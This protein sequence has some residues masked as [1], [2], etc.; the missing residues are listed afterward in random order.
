MLRTL[1]CTLVFC[2][3]LICLGCGA[4]TGDSTE[5]SGD[6]DSSVGTEKALKD[7]A[8]DH[9]IR[10]G[11]NYDYELRGET[12]DTIFEE[13]FNAMTAGTFW[14]DG[15]Y[16]SRTESDFSEMDAKVDWGHERGMELHG[17]ILV[18]F[19]DIPD[20]V[21]SAPTTDVESIMN[22]HIDAVVGRYAGKITVWDV[23]NEAVNDGVYDY[24]DGPAGTLRRDHKWFEAMG[25]DYIAKAFVR[26]HA[27]DPT[28]ILRYND[29]AMESNQ[30]KYEGV[31]NLLQ[32]LLD[33][34]V[35]VHALGWQMHVKPGS[36]D[37][38]TLLA[39]MNEIADMGLDNYITE[40]DVELPEEATADDYEQQKQTFKSVIEVF[41]EAKRH[42]T[43]VF[44]GLRDG[45]PHWLTDGHPL[46]F[47]ED[48]NKKAA[49]DGVQE[50][51]SGL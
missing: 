31:K 42:Q 2:V 35:P 5:D 26:A 25:D 16:P 22:E 28:A 19:D 7:L 49:Y 3:L 29:Y 17:H 46:L 11:A 6:G 34:G 1:L 41:L 40:L 27:A 24:D 4:A 47:D 50:A 13:E 20:W 15:S 36:F 8:T 39:R 21:K 33:E 12:H 51:L 10:I 14:T 18:W 48:L 9:G 43:L 38:E 32:D 23:V 45:G 30:A 37:S 44:W